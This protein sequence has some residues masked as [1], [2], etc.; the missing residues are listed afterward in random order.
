ML[1]VGWSISE[2]AVRERYGAGFWLN[3]DGAIWPGLPADTFAA[4]GFQGQTT[5]IIPSH[6]LVVVHLGASRVASRAHEIAAGVIAS[7][8]ERT[9]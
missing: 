6:D 3:P 9:P 2:E 1:S 5:F 4:Q 7:L 8:R